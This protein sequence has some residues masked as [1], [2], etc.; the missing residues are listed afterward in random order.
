MVLAF[1]FS[2][3]WGYSWPWPIIAILGIAVI[4]MI[5]YLHKIP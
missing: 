4:A 1:V 2:L 5:V 3:S